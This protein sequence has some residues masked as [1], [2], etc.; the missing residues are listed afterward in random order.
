[1]ATS[2][3]VKVLKNGAAADI[4]S[5]RPT[6]LGNS[7]PAQTGTVTFQFPVLDLSAGSAAKPARVTENSAVALN[8]DMV[9]P[10]FEAIDATNAGPVTDTE[11]TGRTAL[12]KAVHEKTIQETRAAIEADVN[13][14]IGGLR[15]KLVETIDRISS[16]AKEITA[17]METEV[18]ELA[19]E[20]AKKVTTREVTTDP[21]VVLAVT[22]TALTKLHSRT[23]ATIHLHPGDLAF[24]QE[25][26]DR[27]N[28]HGSLE[29]IEDNSITPGG[30]LIHTDSGDIDA[31][32]ESQFDE[33][34][35]G[36]LGQ[37]S[38]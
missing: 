4:A 12:E 11:W 18:V 24:V 26:R 3:L 27:L 8:G 9:F 25:N 19:V 31:R 15:E 17:Q 29:L 32:I 10:Q 36:L 38:N 14:Q 7:A 2:T 13:A 30:C 6:E 20:I 35:H 28:F 37:R 21:E 34:A 23:L 5:F 33:I 22:R 16:L 1:M